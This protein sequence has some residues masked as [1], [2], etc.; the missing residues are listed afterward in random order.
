MQRPL[1]VMRPMLLLLEVGHGLQRQGG[2]LLFTHVV[3]DAFVFPVGSQQR[4]SFLA[5]P[6]ARG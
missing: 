5:R 4:G 6:A 3:K 2:R 1:G